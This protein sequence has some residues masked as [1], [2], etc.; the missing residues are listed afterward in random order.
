MVDHYELRRF[1]SSVRGL[2]NHYAASKLDLGKIGTSS[3]LFWNLIMSLGITTMPNIPLNPLL[4]IEKLQMDV[5]Q[6]AGWK[7]I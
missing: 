6:K 4:C 5:L 7:N 3:L 2:N 1:F